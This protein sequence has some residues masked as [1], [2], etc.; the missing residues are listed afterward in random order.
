MKM[1]YYLLELDEAAGGNEY[2]TR[3]V[4]ESEDRQMVKYHYHSRLKDIGY[5]DTQ[6]GKHCLKGLNTGLTEIYNIRSLSRA[7]Y[8]FLSEYL[9]KWMKV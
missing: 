7:E 9:P 2:T 3:H 4:I 5:S 8:K 6:Y 1:S